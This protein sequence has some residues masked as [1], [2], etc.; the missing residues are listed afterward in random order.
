MRVHP[1]AL[2]ALAAISMLALAGSWWAM[3]SLLAWLGWATCEVVRWYCE[4]RT[5]RRRHDVQAFIQRELDRMPRREEPTRRTVL[6]HASAYPSAWQP[7]ITQR[8]TAVN[9]GGRACRR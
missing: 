3:V 2:T 5:D 4:Y 8:H 6:M 9:D 7:F 1:V